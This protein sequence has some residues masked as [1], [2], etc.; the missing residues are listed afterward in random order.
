[1]ERILIRMADTKVVAQHL[2][3]RYEPLRAVTLIGRT[4]QKALFA[5]RS[6]EVVFWALVHAHYRGGELCGA[7]EAELAA[8]R[9]SI[10]P[11]VV[12]L[13]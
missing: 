1:M 10:V 6:D 4:M 3:A 11:D 12:D 7:T 13:H 9:A 2:H 8:F 5:G